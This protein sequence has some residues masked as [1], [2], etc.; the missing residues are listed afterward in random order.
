[1]T[2]RERREAL[3]R[4]AKC[5]ALALTADTIE[6]VEKWSSLEWSLREELRPTA[7]E[8][9]NPSGIE[10]QTERYHQIYQQDGCERVKAEG[11]L[12]AMQ[13]QTSPEPTDQP[14]SGSNPRSTRSK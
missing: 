12:L 13:S 6:E 7:A 10:W 11:E 14:P 5:G 1:M 8:Q 2:V 3:D 9:H 4:I